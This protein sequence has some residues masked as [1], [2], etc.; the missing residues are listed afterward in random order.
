MSEVITT[1]RA[2]EGWQERADPPA[3]TTNSPLGDL[4]QKCFE[5]AERHLDRIKVW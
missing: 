1:F 3:Q 4:S 2:T 5:L